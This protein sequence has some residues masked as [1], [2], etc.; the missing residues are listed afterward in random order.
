MSCTAPGRFATETTR[1]VQSWPEAFG[2]GMRIRMGE[3][4]EARP[5]VRVVLDRRG[6][7]EEAVLARRA[8]ARDAGERIVEAGEARA[9]GVAR[10]RPP[11]GVRQVHGSATRGIAPAPAGARRRRRRRRANR[12]CAAGC[13]ARRG[14]SRRRSCSGVVEEQVERARDDAFARVLDRH[15]AEVGGAGAGRVEHLVGVGAR[16]AHDRRAEVA[17]RGELAEGSCRAE[18]GDARRRLER[19]ACRHDLAPD[20]RHALGRQGPALACFSASI[21]AAS[22]SGRNAGE[23]SARFSSP[24]DTATRRGG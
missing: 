19:A 10:D 11:L 3:D 2:C 17:E 21:T 13:G 20:R 23:P 5:V 6:D 4:R 18:V 24:I 1:L 9:F 12:S 14:W 8:L 7:D 22:R 15:D 16:Q